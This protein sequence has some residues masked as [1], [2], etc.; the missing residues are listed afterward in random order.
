MLLLSTKR[1][2][3]LFLWLLFHQVTKLLKRFV[4]KLNG[5]LLRYIW[6]SACAILLSKTC[7]D[8]AQVR[9][10]EVEAAASFA[11][12]SAFEVA[13]KT[14]GLSIEGVLNHLVEL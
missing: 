9:M 14:A 8:G 3:L 10:A 7:L 1:K 6:H 4:Q 12:G 5:V 2:T 13:C 11:E